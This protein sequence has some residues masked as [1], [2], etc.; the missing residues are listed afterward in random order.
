MAQICADIALAAAVPILELYQRE[1]GSHVKADGSPVTAADLAADQIIRAN[2]QHTWPDIPIIS[3]EYEIH[4]TT[5]D[6]R[7][8]LVDPLDGT[9]EFLHGT[10]EF[11]VNIA[12][13]E[14][15][16]SV[17]GV[18]YAPVLKH[19]FIAGEA[20]FELSDI[21][22]GHSIASA[23]LSPIRSRQAKRDALTALA[24]RSH[25]DDKTDRLLK[26]LTPTAIR[27]SGSSYKFCLLAKGE[28]DIYPR[29]G[30]TMEWDIAAGHA[31]LRAAGG[32]V[33]NE[34]GKSFEYRGSQTRNGPFLAVG[35]KEFGQDV[36]ADFIQI[37]RSQHPAKT[38]IAE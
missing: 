17:A 24:S 10:G 27:R 29:F 23:K 16:Q 20:A 2:L 22:A 18:I 37:G 34:S 4:D 12:L 25:A 11:T 7:F 1:I 14:N 32:T 8:F 5:H 3:E 26:M 21:S 36:I 30:P 13:I 38:G 31:I 15:H 6:Q 35:D 28:A 9:K 19:L 33:L